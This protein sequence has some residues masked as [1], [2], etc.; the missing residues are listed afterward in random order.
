MARDPSKIDVLVIHTPEGLE[1]VTLAVAE[2]STAGFDFYLTLDGKLHQCNDYQNYVAWQAGEWNT[3]VR[4]IGIEQGDF[5][6]NSG[7]FPQ[8]HYERLATLVAALINCTGIPLQR[9][10]AVGQPGIIA[11]ADVTPAVRTDPGANFKWD[12]L[13][14][15]VSNLLNGPASPPTIDQ[16]EADNPN[17]RQQLVDWRQMRVSQGADPGDYAAFRQHLIDL[18]APDP[19]E[20]EF[21][22]FRDDAANQSGSS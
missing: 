7:E 1:D 15:L 4:G 5:A 3:N 9:A 17:I 12:L 11:H 14:S 8:E 2:G 13:F 20:Q 21:T 16:L 18:G 6:A 10:T 19:G 22:G